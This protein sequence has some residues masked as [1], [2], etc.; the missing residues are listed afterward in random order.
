MTRIPAVLALLAALAACMST[1]P[2][3]APTAD[4]FVVYFQTGD[5]SLTPE[6]RQVVANVV[7]ASK[8]RPDK[9]VVEGHAD[10]GTTTD[11]TLADRRAAAVMRALTDG[12]IDATRVIK[13][14]GAPAPGT[15]GVAAHQVLIHFTPSS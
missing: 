8:T 14:P 13:A 12:G 1:S 9:L 6:A 5:A 2:T 3:P 7:A 11:A 10:G 4:N 15:E